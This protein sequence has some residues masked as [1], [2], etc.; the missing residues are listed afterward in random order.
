MSGWSTELVEAVSAAATDGD[1]SVRQRTAMLGGRE[2]R[3]PSF[4]WIELDDPSVV[5]LPDT[6]HSTDKVSTA[7][8]VSAIV[9]FLA[10]VMAILSVTLSDWLFAGIFAMV[11]AVCGA[12]LWYLNRSP[13]EDSMVVG[14]NGLYL[15]PD[16]LLLVAGAQW[17][18][19]KRGEVAGFGTRRRG[20]VAADTAKFVEYVDVEIGGKQRRIDLQQRVDEDQRAVCEAWLAGTWPL[21]LPD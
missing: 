20:P 4:R 16:A 12:G 17:I 11:T 10:L 18:E 9:G 3:G 5:F 13:V 15:T 19:A 7:M 21:P 14:T 6:H 8:T 2:L 1:V